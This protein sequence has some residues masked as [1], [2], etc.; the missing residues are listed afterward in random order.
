MKT[1]TF[2]F[3]GFIIALIIAMVGILYFNNIVYSERFKVDNEII[4]SV[5]KGSSIS[6]IVEKLNDNGI[7]ISPTEFKIVA[8]WFEIDKNLR[9]G[10]FK[11]AEGNYNLRD[12]ASIFTRGGLVTKT[13]TIP[14]GLRIKDIAG[15]IQKSL[16]VDSLYFYEQCRNRELLKKYN[17]QS[18]TFEGYLYPDTY[19]VDESAT[20]DEII[21]IMVKN[22]KSK[23][24]PYEAQI[25]N[26]GYTK[27][28]IVTLASIIQG[29]VAVMGEVRKISSVY[30][31][32]LKK[33]MLLQADPTIQYMLDKP[34]RLL[35]KHL[36]IDNP[37]NTYMYK[38]LPPTPI[39][40]PS[41]EVID[42]ALNPDT[43]DY[44]FMVAKGNGEHY[45]NVTLKD[46]LSDKAKF[47]KVRR[48]VKRGRK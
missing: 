4:V 13:I 35:H 25:L 18:T 30:N 40:S 26:S 46:H 27:Q 47:D 41:I 7:D 20:V 11:I 6:E 24:A 19:V 43:T 34:K 29:E 39:N 5:K 36:Q 28:E 10:K 3:Y 12:L 2:I 9:Y 1:K 31:N 22:F 44:I 17:I 38:G 16:D 8:R 45:F 48:E 14:E 33:G 42:A 21:D 37:Y 23:I 32:R 15:I